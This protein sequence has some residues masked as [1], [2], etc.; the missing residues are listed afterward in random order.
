MDKDHITHIIEA[1]TDKYVF[2]RNVSLSKV[3]VPRL[4]QIQLFLDNN[5]TDIEGL[6]LFY[7]DYDGHLS[8]VDQSN[9][10]IFIVQPAADELPE[11]LN[12]NNVSCKICHKKFYTSAKW[13]DYEGF[14][15]RACVDEYEQLK[16][17][18]HWS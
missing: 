9:G 14:C 13:S 4:K 10:D 16:A 8:E 1:K 11:S 3:I 12:L 18:N 6:K 17:D 5:E 2:V 15:S 7:V